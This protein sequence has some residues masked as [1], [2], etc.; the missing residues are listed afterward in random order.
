MDNM[1]DIVWSIN[2]QND[3]L[4]SLALRIRAHAAEVLGIMGIQVNLH[5]E[6][7][8][9][10]QLNMNAR[11]NIYLV[12]KESINNI[13]KHSGAT[14]A[15]LSFTAEKGLLCL[16]ISDNGKGSTTN[17]GKGGNGLKNMERRAGELGGKCEFISDMKNGTTVRFQL[18]MTNIHH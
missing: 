17:S 8:E 4:H 18:P 3:T 14:E 1:S 15:S 6:L 12:A 13:A 5:N 11:K 9:D 10:I 2:P 7:K 16:E